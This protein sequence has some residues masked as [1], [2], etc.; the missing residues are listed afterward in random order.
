MAIAL[1]TDDSGRIRKRSSSDDQ[2]MQAYARGKTDAFDQLYLRYKQ[3]LYGYL[4][5]NCHRTEVDE[6]FQEIW[7]RVIASQSRYKGN[8]KFRA[9]I[10]TLAHNCLV[11]HY[12]K[13]ERQAFFCR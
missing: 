12:R 4:Y 10:F 3:P 2:L 11:D 7:L 13:T 8:N 5:R 6:L 9:W 1:P